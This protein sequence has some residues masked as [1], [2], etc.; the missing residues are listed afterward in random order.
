MLPAGGTG[1]GAGPGAAG[2]AAPAGFGVM[3]PQQSRLAG[4]AP[5]QA[6]LLLSL[7]GS[8]LYV[9]TALGAVMLLGRFIPIVLVLALA[10]SLAAQDKVPATAGTLPTHRPMFIG[11]VI[12]TI[13]IVASLTYFPVLALGPLAEGL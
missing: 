2:E 12:G 9:G 13:L 5:A 8:M 7:N 6:P 3:A 11:L 10:G 1:S 4:M